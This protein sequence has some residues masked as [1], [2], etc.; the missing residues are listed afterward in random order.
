[1]GDNVGFRKLYVRDQNMDYYEGE[2]GKEIERIIQAK[3]RS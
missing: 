1:V 2:D 3:S